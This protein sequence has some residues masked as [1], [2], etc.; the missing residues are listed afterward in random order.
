MELWGLGDLSFATPLLAKAVDD[1]VHVVS[2]PHARPLLAPSFPFLKFWDCD[3]PWTRYSGKYDLRRWNW[4]ALA[5]IVKKLRAER[6]DIA[7]SVRND[8]RDHLLMRL[9]G[10]KQ[11]YGFPYRGSGIFLNH[12]LHRADSQQHKVED[13]RAIGQ[14]LGYPQ[15]QEANPWLDPKRYHAPA[16]SGV[17]DSEDNASHPQMTQMEQTS[18]NEA[19]VAGKPGACV[20]PV[21]ASFPLRESADDNAIHLRTKQ[22]SSK[23]I[24][25]LHT[26][27]RIPVRRWKEEYFAEIV[28][29][30]RA[31]YDFHLVLIPDPDGFGSGLKPL[32]DTVLTPI[33]IGELV[34]AIEK[35]HLL[36]CNDS[37]PAHIAAALGRPTITIFGPSNPSWFRPWGDLHHVIIRDICPWRPCFDY[38]TFPEPYCMTKL[39]P[40]TAWPEVQGHLEKLIGLGIFP[41]LR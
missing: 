19:S 32:A 16:I 29:R 30:L 23:P 37:G 9:I 21:T 6:F 36:L 3:A 4:P 10:A 13:W 1:E 35:S 7:V 38:C 2:K 40:R 27:A 5:G 15:M 39:F 12:P 25:T 33:S 24:L 14:A 8:P 28:E 17:L 11:R 20:S 34:F 41:A 22:P 26:G 31:R 18:K